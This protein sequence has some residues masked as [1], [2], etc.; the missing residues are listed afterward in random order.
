MFDVV[1]MAS[2]INHIDEKMC[3][4]LSS[5]PKARETYMDIF[6]KLRTL[7]KN[8]GKLIITD[9]SNRNFWGDIGLNNIFARNI[10][11]EKHQ[12][13]KYWSNLL[14]SAGFSDPKISLGVDYRLHYR[15]IY[16][17]PWVLSCF[18]TSYF[19]LEMT[20]Q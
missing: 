15:G 13:P 16:K 12:S 1:L 4:E 10:N 20:V 3:M 19:R 2:S 14:S 9:C 18:S 17:V 7:M 11:W 5:N 6:G 8:H